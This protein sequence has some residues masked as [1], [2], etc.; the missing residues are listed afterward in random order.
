MTPREKI[1]VYVKPKDLKLS[2]LNLKEIYSDMIE[3]RMEKI[4]IVDDQNNIIGLA[5]EKDL[6]NV[7]S[8]SISNIN[9]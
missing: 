8:N 3:S 9:K 2:S 4:P 1:K 5:S 6:R 7:H